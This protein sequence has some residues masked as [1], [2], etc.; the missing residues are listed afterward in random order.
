MRVAMLAV[1]ICVVG[2]HVAI[3]QEASIVEPVA[4]RGFLA[5]NGGYQLTQDDFSNGAIKHEHAEDGRFDTDYVFKGGPSFDG[6]VGLR[7]WR[8]LSIGVGVS[9]LSVATPAS[10]RASVPHPFLF[11]SGSVNQRRGFGRNARGISRAHA[12][13]RC[14]SDRHQASGDGV[15]WSLV[16]SGHA[17]NRHGRYLYQ[18]LSLRR[19]PIRRCD[20]NRCESLESGIQR[21]RGSG[22]LL[23]ETR[24]SGRNRAVFRDDGGVACCRWRKSRREGRRRHSQWGPAPAILSE[25]HMH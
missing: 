13:W 12:N 7:L 22:L 5:M 20:N 21:R 17:G 11:L 18:R 3:A 4:S 2:T 16:L 15:W 25:G 10:V 23:D 1:V 24:R 8:R 19:G 6:A 14:V 9:R